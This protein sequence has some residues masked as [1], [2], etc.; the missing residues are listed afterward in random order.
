MHVPADTCEHATRIVIS[1]YAR[2]T[3]AT[4]SSQ[5]FLAFSPNL[6]ASFFETL[7]VPHATTR[8]SHLHLQSYTGLTAA[9]GCPST[10]PDP[11]IMQPRPC[12]SPATARRR[13]RPTTA[14]ATP[15]QPIAQSADSPRYH[16]WRHRGTFGRSVTVSVL[17][18]PSGQPRLVA[19]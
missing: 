15:H 17:A 16:S 19:L 4:I 12:Y 3:T 2:S 9:T 14:A 1:I 18:V 10:P 13:K 5:P 6:F 8:A 7:R 11:I